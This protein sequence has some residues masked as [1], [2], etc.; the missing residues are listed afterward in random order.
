MTDT[1]RI[2]ALEARLRALEELL[3]TVGPAVALVDLLASGSML[4]VT[5][6]AEHFGLRLTVR[7]TPPGERPDFTIESAR[8]PRRETVQ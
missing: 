6:L 8:P 5:R 4:A 2:A 7:P 1:E 3:E